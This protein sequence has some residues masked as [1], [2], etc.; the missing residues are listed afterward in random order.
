MLS[1]PLTI[2][3]ADWLLVKVDD[4]KY[5]PQQCFH[6][7][8]FG[9]ISKYCRNANKTCS[10]CANPGHSSDQCGGEM[11]CLHCASRTHKS[12]DKNCPKYVCETEFINLHMRNRIPRQEAMD[13]VFETTL[14][15][16]NFYRCM[17]ESSIP[18]LEQSDDSS[19]VSHSQA[20]QR[21]VP[22]PLPY[23]MTC[24]QQPSTSGVSQ[25]QTTSLPFESNPKH[26]VQQAAHSTSLYKKSSIDVKPTKQKL[27][28]K[29]HIPTKRQSQ[30][31]YSDTVKRRSRSVEKHTGTKPKIKDKHMRRNSL[32]NYNQREEEGIFMSIDNSRKRGLTSPEQ[33]SSSKKSNLT[34]SR[35]SLQR[36]KPLSYTNSQQKLRHDRQSSNNT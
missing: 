12:T 8:K 35:G 31:S 27:E 11:K 1:C 33:E 36:L 13:K 22:T 25:S 14:Q 32:I 7:L 15:Y 17:N 34:Q 24:T 16:E 28:T 9:H 10:V 20:V 30:Q 29:S 4:Y 21:V 26:H 23:Q 5:S 19:N 3:L 18:L 6:C 2:K